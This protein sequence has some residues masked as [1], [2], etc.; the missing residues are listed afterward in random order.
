M[1]GK[2]VKDNRKLEITRDENE[3]RSLRVG[4]HFSS[5]RH[6]CKK[7]AQVGVSPQVGLSVS[8]FAPAEKLDL[9]SSRGA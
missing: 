4:A 5:F 3:V 8:L 7:F 2:R 1:K 9:V 6:D